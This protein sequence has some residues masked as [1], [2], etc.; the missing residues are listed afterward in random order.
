MGG[1]VVK[2]LLSADGTRR[3]DIFERGDGT[4][5]FEEFRFDEGELCWLASGCRA[6][7]FTDNLGDALRE[8]RGRVWWLAEGQD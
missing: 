6:T 3:V 8:A 7:S 1:Q 4:F 5:G 2:S